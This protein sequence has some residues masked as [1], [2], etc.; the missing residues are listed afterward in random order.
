MVS[1]PIDRQRLMA[2]YEQRLAADP[3]SRAFLPLAELYRR[4][5]RHQD[6]RRILEA[7][8]GRHPG[9]RLG[10]GGPGPGPPGPGRGRPAPG[11]SSRGCVSA[12]RTTSSRC[13]CWRRRPR[14]ATTG[15][16]SSSISSASCGSSRRTSRRSPGSR[17]PATTVA[18]DLAGRARAGA[19]GG[20]R[21][22]RAVVPGD[23]VGGVVTLTLADLYLRQGYTDRAREL[24]SRM[25]AAEPDREDV[26]ERLV[27]LARGRSLAGGARGR[28][29]LRRRTAGERLGRAPAVRVLAGARERG[30]AAARGGPSLP[31]VDPDA[32]HWAITS[33]QNRHS[34][35]GR[36]RGGHDQFPHGLHDP[37]QER[38]VV[39]RGIPSRQARQGRR[40]RAHQAQERDQR[41]G[42][43]GDLPRPARRWTRCASSAAT[44]STS[45]TTA[46][47]TPS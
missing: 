5:A 19:G 33:D 43:R 28:T 39:H 14:T 20:G 6:A 26:R 17:P 15:P 32:I 2:L 13:G 1:D 12:I 29:S 27:R 23:T 42:R 4:D 36:Q 16:A 30:L 44:T 25:A 3:G 47:S 46:S 9:L 8:L 35:K 7:G 37:F 11:R 38:S 22:R 40:L 41:Q 21:E 31:S 45:T 34:Q 10:P 24:L 18:A